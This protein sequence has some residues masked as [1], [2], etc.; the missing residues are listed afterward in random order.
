MAKDSWY[1]SFRETYIDLHVAYLAVLRL[2]HQRKD[3]L[4]LVIQKD[5]EK[6]DPFEMGSPIGGDA[7]KRWQALWA[8]HD[9]DDLNKQAFLAVAE[10]QQNHWKSWT[11]FMDKCPP[12]FGKFKINVPVDEYKMTATTVTRD[13][14]MQRAKVLG[15]AWLLRVKGEI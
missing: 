15:K 7:A 3:S 5:M 14:M 9:C 13:T 12:E 10:A 11:A 8:K 1:K 6:K 2:R 4:E